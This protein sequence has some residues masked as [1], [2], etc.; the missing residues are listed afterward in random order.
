MR[1]HQRNTLHPNQLSYKNSQAYYTSCKIE[2][3]CNKAL[4]FMSYCR[5]KHFQLQLL[6]YSCSYQKKVLGNSR[7]WTE[8]IADEVDGVSKTRQMRVLL[9]KS[10]KT[11]LAK[12]EDERAGTRSAHANAAAAYETVTCEVLTQM[13]NHRY[14]SL[15]LCRPLVQFCESFVASMVISRPLRLCQ[16]PFL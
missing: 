14:H 11:T 16:E 4:S 3:Y 1:V 15:T 5:R 10:Y 13:R 7:R 9:P 6:E 12:C 8:G 2:S